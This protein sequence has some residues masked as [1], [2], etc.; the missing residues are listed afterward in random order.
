M[1]N[2]NSLN[3][4]KKVCGFYVSSIHLITMIL[5]YIKKQI[6]EE[7][8]IETFFEYNLKENINNI[9]QKIIISPEEKEKILR[10]DWNRNKI[11][12]YSE[13]EKFLKE[14]ID[15]NNSVDLLISGNR[16]Y[17]SNIN[18]M[19]E[20]FFLKNENKINN[21]NIT[22]I[23]CFEVEEFD[24]NIREILESHEY[25]LNTSGMHKIGDVFEDFKYKQEK[26]N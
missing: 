1:S 3:Y 5:P 24:D 25:I 8:S 14:K 16:K 4:I 23:N 17:I 19:L 21:K 22:I 9:V 20:K 7:I 15:N 11:K 6:E 26:A 18:N 2:L 10:I 12:K 13:I